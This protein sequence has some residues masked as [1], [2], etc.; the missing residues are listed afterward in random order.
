LN[1]PDMFSAWQRLSLICANYAKQRAFLSG[2]SPA[3]SGRTPRTSVFGSAQ[4]ACLAQSCWP[5]SRRHWAWPSRTSW[6][7]RVINGLRHRAASSGPL[8]SRRNAF[9]GVSKR[10]WRSLCESSLPSIQTRP[11]NPAHFST[12]PHHPTLNGRDGP[13]LLPGSSRPFNISRSGGGSRRHDGTGLV[14]LAGVLCR[15]D[16]CRGRGD[17]GRPSTPAERIAAK[18]VSLMLS[19]AKK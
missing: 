19:L 8:S 1:H 17:V 7:S 10:S 5:P 12:R 16:S 9:P 18:R 4:A 3:S 15:R 13:R 14:A 2:N 11:R 6:A